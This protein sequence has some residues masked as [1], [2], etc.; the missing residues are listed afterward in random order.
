[1]SNTVCL[2]NR[3]TFEKYSDSVDTSQYIYGVEYE[4]NKYNVFKKTGQNNKD[5]PCAVCEVESRGTHLMVPGRNLCPEGWTLEYQGYLMS[6]HYGH[7]GRSS[8]ICVDHDA[9]G[10][11]RTEKDL[12]GNL[13]Y[14]LQAA[15]GSLPC[16]PYIN[17]R[18]LTCAV[19]TR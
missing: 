16:G 13:W 6:E 3:P 19:C 8:A 14:T 7:K 18:E 10:F 9:E 5:A 17:G 2:H 4:V 12:N 15:C 1:M 11:P